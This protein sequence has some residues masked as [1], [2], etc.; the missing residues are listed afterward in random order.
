VL[1]R[2]LPSLS[3]VKEM[4]K[5]IGKNQL[6]V[7]MFIE[8]IEGSWQDS[9]LSGR[10]FTLTSE[11]DADVIKKSPVDGIFINTSK[12]LDVLSASAD[13]QRIDLRGMDGGKALASKDRNNRIAIGKKIAKT[14]TLLKGVF[15]DVSA[16]GAVTVEMVAPVMAQII[17]SLNIAPSVF[18]SMTRLKSKDEVT[19]IH[20]LSVSALMIQFAR[21]LEFDAEMVSILGMS[22]LLHD[23]GKVRM[24]A[25]I[26]TNTGVLSNQE[27][28]LMRRHPEIG[29]HMLSRSKG[30]SDIVLDVCLHHH[31]RLDGKG[32]PFGLAGDEISIFA[33]MAAICDVYDALTSVRPY[34]K[35]WTS[36]EAMAF[37]LDAS[38][39]FDPLLLQQ[40]ITEVIAD[41]EYES[42]QSAD[43]DS[44]T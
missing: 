5:R 11:T 16:G 12:G 15:E 37:M 7:G 2:T 27:M 42:Y 28:E 38:G 20:S 33:K 44:Q 32:Y 9:P 21:H 1:N 19:F 22:G 13:P 35:P 39:A 10:R 24:P 6:R 34:K 43:T 23:I 3:K 25:N 17:T 29:H 4:L 14:S 30:M 40:F 8:A 36:S 18:I 41:N 26:L 31:E